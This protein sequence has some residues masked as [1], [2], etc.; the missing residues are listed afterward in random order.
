MLTFFTGVPGFIG[1]RLARRLLADAGRR[2]ACLVYPDEKLLEKARRF[3]G[4]D[5]RIEIVPGDITRPRLG[6]DERTWDRL[7]G[8]IEEVFHL[9]A[10]YNLAAPK[11]RSYEVNVEGTRRVLDLCEAA[12]P[13]LRRLVY[14]S[15]IVVSGDRRGTIYEEDL[16]AGQRF[17]N[18]YEETKF[19]AEVEVRR[20]MRE[21]PTAIVRPA[22]VIG[23]SKT[24]EIDKYDGP[25]YFI[26]ALVRLEKKGEKGL[27][28]RILTAG[29]ADA[30]F[31]LVPVDFLVEATHAIATSPAAIG[32]T[33]HV[34]DPNEMKVDEVRSLVAARFG[35]PE[36]P[37][38]VPAAVL[39]ALFRIPGVERLSRMPRQTLDYFDLDNRYDDANTRTV[40]AARGIA[41][42]RLPDY[43]DTLLAF[44][45]QH[46]EIEVQ[47]LRN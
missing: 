11:V 14:I 43:L 45:R 2:L 34:V 27:L 9:A 25:Y 18:Y 46:R 26:D 8:E 3:A 44:V 24:G 6:L 28:A 36:F 40:T 41:C 33:F 42:P 7:R 39:R 31:H 29:S 32:R 38:R 12:L 4:G 37:V 30:R 47:F 21:L 23:D 17:R 15:T 20:R 35:L 22:V 1:S 19:L 13:R 16:E 10:L 5:E